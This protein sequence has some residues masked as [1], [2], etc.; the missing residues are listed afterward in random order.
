MSSGHYHRRWSANTAGRTTPTSQTLA[1]TVEPS[2]YGT[3]WNSVRWNKPST[4][5]YRSHSAA[6]ASRFEPKPKPFYT[7]SSTTSSATPRTTTTSRYSNANSE[8]AKIAAQVASLGPSVTTRASRFDTTTRDSASKYRS[9]ARDIINKWTSRE[10]N[11]DQDFSRVLRI[12]A[13]PTSYYS[14]H[15]TSRKL[16][17]DNS[18]LSRPSENVAANGYLNKPSE[19][20]YRKSSSV[21]PTRSNASTVSRY[22]DKTSILSPSPTP[23]SQPQIADPNTA[24][25][26]VPRAERPWRQRL[27]ESSR[28]RASLGDDYR[29]RLGS[30]DSTASA[31]RARTSYTP[32]FAINYAKPQTDTHPKHLMSRS[33]SPI[34]PRDE[35]YK[36][37]TAVEKP[38]LSKART[39]DRLSSSQESLREERKLHAGVSTAP[40][41]PSIRESSLEREAERPKKRSSKERT[42]RRSSR[43]QAYN[44]SSTSEE[45][46]DRSLNRADAKR[47]RRRRKESSERGVAFPG[48]SAP[49]GMPK[50][51]DTSL[52]LAR[53]DDV[54]ISPARTQPKTNAIS[55]PPVVSPPKVTPIK[56]MQESTTPKAGSVEV[57][58][59]PLAAKD[60]KGVIVIEVGGPL[61]SDDPK[62]SVKDASSS[63]TAVESSTTARPQKFTTDASSIPE[64]ESQYSAVVLFKPNKP[65]VKRVAPVPG[66][67]KVAGADEFI[68]KNKR[69]VRD[70][71]ER[72]TAFVWEVRP[73]ARISKR[74]KA[75][76]RKVMAPPPPPVTVA[77][78][79]A[80]VVVKPTPKQE[81]VKKEEKKE[82]KELK[83]NAASGEKDKEQ[84]KGSGASRIKKLFTAKTRPSVPEQAKV[85]KNEEK[86]EAT[87]PAQQ[88]QE[89][90]KLDSKPKET[91]KIEAPKKTQVK[92]GSSKDEKISVAEAQKKT[93]EKPAKPAVQKEEKTQMSTTIKS[94]SSRAEGISA[95]LLAP[96]W[97][98]IRNTRKI[99]ECKPTATRNVHHTF[100]WMPTPLM[101]KKT[102]QQKKKSTSSA[103]LMCKA[104][105][106][107]ASSCQEAFRKKPVQHGA[108]VIVDKPMPD[109][110][111]CRIRMRIKRPLPM[112]VPELHIPPKQLSSDRES[113][114]VRLRSVDSDAKASPL[115]SQSRASE[116]LDEMRHSEPA[117]VVRRSS[118]EEDYNSLGFLIL[119]DQSLLEEYVKR[120]RGRLERLRSEPIPE[121]DEPR[122]HSPANSTASELLPACAVRV[123]ERSPHG[124]PVITSG[125][126]RSVSRLSSVSCATPTTP[127]AMV[128]TLSTYNNFNAKPQA[129][130]REPNARIQIAKPIQ[131][132][133]P[134]TPFEERLQQQAHAIRKASAASLAASEQD[135]HSSPRRVSHPTDGMTSLSNSYTAALA[136]NTNPARHER[137]AA[138]IPVNKGDNS[139]RQSTASQ[140]S[141][142]SVALDNATKQLDQV[143]DQARHKHS[144]HRNKFKEAIDY[145]DQI[146]EDLKKEVDTGVE[147]KVK[148]RNG[149]P[150]AAQ[151]PSTATTSP[152]DNIR[153]PTVIHPN[154]SKPST[155][156]SNSNVRQV[157]PVQPPSPVEIV[158]PPPPPPAETESVDFDVT[159]TIVLPKKTDKLDFT[160]R[161]LQDDLMSLAHQPPAPIMIMPEQCSY[162]NDVDEHSLGSCSAEVAAINL[163]GKREK[164]RKSNGIAKIASLEKPAPIR[165]Q[166]CRPQ[167]VYAPPPKTSG[168][169]H[170]PVELEVPPIQRVSSFDHVPDRKDYT[171]TNTWRS[172]SQ[173]PYQTQGSVISEDALRPS[174]S[175]FQSVSSFSNRGNMRGSL[176]SLPDAGLIIRGRYHQVTPPKDPTLAIDQLCAELELNTEQPM[177]VQDKRRSFPTSFAH[178]NMYTATNTAYEQPTRRLNERKAQPYQQQQQQQQQQQPKPLYPTAISTHQPVLQT[179]STPL[180]GSN[181][182]NNSSSRLS[183]AQ[184]QPAQQTAPQRSA[185]PP[186]YTTHPVVRRAPQ[187]QQKS[188]DEVTNM[189]NN[190]VNEF[191]TTQQQQR[192]KPAQQS[193]HALYATPHST[194]QSNPFE[195]INQEKINP[196]RVE[197][198]HNMFERNAAPAQSRWSHQ[199]PAPFVAAR[200]RD[201]DNYHEINE[202]ST[203][204]LKRA[205]PPRQAN[206][207]A[208]RHSPQN[209]VTEYTPPYPSTQPPSHPPGRNGSATSSQNGGYYS[210]NSSGVGAP[211]YQ[212]QMTARRSSIVGHQSISSRAPSIADDDD[213]DGF[214]DNIGTYD[215][216]RFSRGSEMDVTSLS[217]HQLPPH[218]GWKPTKIGSFLRKIG[219]GSRPPGSAASLVSLNKVA[220]ETP[221]KAGVLMKSNSLSNEPWKKMVMDG[222]S[223][224]ARQPT[225]NKGGF[226]TRIKNSIFGSKKRLNG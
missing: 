142:Q 144:Q 4:T 146:F 150:V 78:P 173:E 180:N 26:S 46:I 94:K 83:E 8:A 43:Q 38:P 157:K 187:R 174:P 221:I 98:S 77:P 3:S 155:S 197:A 126:S 131:F 214:Y 175:A 66:L 211:A 48:N 33:Y 148:D 207:N 16:F 87:K 184:H 24:N 54:K 20:H 164:P 12:P 120:K 119:P 25:F 156:T 34:R 111:I 209:F 145:L 36:S 153:R 88:N 183:Q 60:A 76:P 114:S 152:P 44:Q 105:V 159:E 194:N 138:H 203:R 122:C 13:K 7:P 96:M 137:Y 58:K 82:A 59:K 89:V 154:Q 113:S 56:L 110:N 10:R 84:K 216:R 97:L 21:T 125:P 14:L 149:A 9:E 132:D 129:F 90:E 223:L 104:S 208:I 210:S 79:P 73:H 53:Q 52:R 117:H 115:L 61:K 67:W 199:A 118:K 225:P 55:P 30:T 222:P 198:M 189:L 205:T 57:P 112:P 219:G 31:P 178:E 217:S 171:N 37:L 106:V 133:P 195:T 140:D 206:T 64:D 186:A 32:S 68:S 81:E 188:L 27:A 220:N 5:G 70:Q 147:D 130:L 134:K 181:I 50:S 92:N 107:N 86:I 47:R 172:G 100:Y 123:F 28:I 128:E 169:R 143:I 176:R 135:R 108:Q 62:R 201:D 102:L 192:R 151:Q 19:Y 121:R 17:G 71:Q 158:L 202:F 196:S 74:T 6:I 127:S 95:I 191:H 45:E 162:Y 212:N 160:R 168:L 177:S 42:A 109:I 49:N 85:E 165:P 15:F 179:R 161:W 18:F 41:N 141:Q 182:N 218:G 22:S 215:D 116:V 91:K 40:K 224:P 80:A 103:S 204:Q 139:G 29:S 72:G 39:P 2:T 193:S 166:P 213:D 23:T 75:S 69:F 93:E 99:R 124:V 136:A 167:P 185:P 65:K 200:P 170:F 226:G 11:S 163:A 51:P 190:V 101:A 35:I 63:S 1:S